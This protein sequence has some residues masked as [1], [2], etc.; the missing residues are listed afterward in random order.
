MESEK[1]LIGQATKMAMDKDTYMYRKTVDE[2]NS[3]V[4]ARIKP[5]NLYDCCYLVV[6]LGETP[7]GGSRCWNPTAEDLIADDWEV[8]DSRISSKTNQ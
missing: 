1:M 4:K 6:F 5:T 3:E 8:I 2:R 7:K